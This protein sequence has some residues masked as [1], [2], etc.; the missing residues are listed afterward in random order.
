MRRVATA[1]VV[2][3]ALLC[4][5]AAVRADVVVNI[6]KSQQRL[7]VTIDGAEIYRWPISTGRRAYPTPAGKFRPIRL[8]RDW[9]SRKYNM[10]PMPYS[11]FFYR[12]YAVHGTL[13]A[14]KLGRAVS[15]GCVRLLPSNASILFDLVR[16]RGMRS[17]RVVVLNGALPKSYS[18][19]LPVPRPPSKDAPVGVAQLPVDQPQ[20]DP[21]RAAFGHAVDE[22]AAA[23][24]K[25]VKKTAEPASPP[26]VISRTRLTR[27]DYRVSIGSEA[28]VLREREL[29]LRSLDRKYGIAR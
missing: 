2:S 19:K 21:A 16:E 25:T 15:H 3:G 4:P 22:L 8:E 26:A 13:E 10:T 24:T 17:T 5:P 20:S 1:I 6:S 23:Q 18:P 14:R 9:Y 7:A 11:I 28:Q 27:L 29:W 12:G